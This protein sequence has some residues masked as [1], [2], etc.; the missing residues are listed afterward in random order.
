MILTFEEDRDKY[1]G[2]IVGVG[3]VSTY[4]KTFR[5]YWATK[6]SFLRER[7][8]W[9]MSRSVGVYESAIVKLM[10]EKMLTLEGKK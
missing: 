2:E 8:G 10:V 6:T 4:E 7:I 1:A 5:K 9:R 3:F